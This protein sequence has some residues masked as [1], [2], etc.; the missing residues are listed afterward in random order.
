MCP[1]VDVTSPA[2]KTCRAVLKQLLDQ[3]W[4]AK[5][6]GNLTQLLNPEP[7]A[8][9]ATVAAAGGAVHAVSCGGMVLMCILCRSFA[10]TKAVCKMQE[11]GYA[12]SPP[13]VQQ[14]LN[15]YQS[16]NRAKVLQP[17]CNWTIVYMQS[18]QPLQ[19]SSCCCCSCYCL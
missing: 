9:K 8:A 7:Q 5:V 17:D 13:A 2:S 14:P 18:A 10:C 12:Q 11:A 6:F 16:W 15:S 4:A 1:A 19:F 3:D